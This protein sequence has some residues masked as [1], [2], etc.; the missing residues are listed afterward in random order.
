MSNI[1]TQLL[2]LWPTLT[3]ALEVARNTC[4]Y[5]MLDRFRERV[6]ETTLTSGRWATQLRVELGC[7]LTHLS[8]SRIYSVLQT[9]V[10]LSG[11]TDLQKH[12][13]AVSYA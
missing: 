10:R 7:K 4:T 9:L 5:R 8:Q 13:A 6:E 11:F 3:L 2:T 12:K 1:H